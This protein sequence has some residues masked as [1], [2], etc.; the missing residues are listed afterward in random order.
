M[1]VE[2]INN[3]TETKN[4]MSRFF[5]WTTKASM[6]TPVMIRRHGRSRNL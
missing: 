6:I 3:F 4:P 2:A 1:V 5:S